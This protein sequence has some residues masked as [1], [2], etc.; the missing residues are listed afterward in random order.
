MKLA[1]GDAVKKSRQ[2]RE[3]P[4]EMQY[5]PKKIHKNATGLRK[6]GEAE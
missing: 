5:A 2:M 4:H 3:K 1:R 6:H